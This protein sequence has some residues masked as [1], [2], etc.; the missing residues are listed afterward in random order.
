MNQK[1]TTPDTFGRFDMSIFTHTVD[2]ALERFTLDDGTEIAVGYD[3]D[4]EEP[5]G[6]GDTWNRMAIRRVE[7]VYEEWHGDEK[8]YKA[9]ELWEESESMDMTDEEK[10][11]YYGEVPQKPGRE[12]EIQVTD[13]YGWPK[14]QVIVGNDFWEHHGIVFSE[15]RF[16][17]EAEALAKEWG[18]WAEGKVYLIE[19]TNPDGET[20]YVGNVYEDVTPENIHDYL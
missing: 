15:E 14:F 9:W 13:L 11:S 2:R 8:L 18:V 16:E 6:M 19:V 4:A 7:R 12:V 5:F 10:E 17:Q 3:L 1:I 20:Y